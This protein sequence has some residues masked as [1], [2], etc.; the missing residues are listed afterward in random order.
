MEM[1]DL[2]VFVYQVLDWK[3]GQ[4]YAK[5]IRGMISVESLGLLEALNLFLIFASKTI[6]PSSVRILFLFIN[7]LI[8]QQFL[9]TTTL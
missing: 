5:I 7:I 9:G 2:D 4:F 3:F 8:Q 1:C 6:A